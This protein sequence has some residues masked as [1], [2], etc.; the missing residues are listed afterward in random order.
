MPTAVLLSFAQFEREL[1]GERVRDKIAASKRKGT[2][3][4]SPVPLGYAAVNKKILV[5]AA[6]VARASVNRETV[7][8]RFIRQNRLSNRVFKSFDDIVGYCYYA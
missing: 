3:V 7:N 2:W 5:V 6:E 8:W 4:G 1:I